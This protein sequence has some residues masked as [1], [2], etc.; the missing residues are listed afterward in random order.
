MQEL[1]FGKMKFKGVQ[2][3]IAKCQ[4][5]QSLKSSFPSQN[6]KLLFV[7]LQ[8]SINYFKGEHAKIQFCSK[9]EINYC[10]VYCEY[11]VKV[12]KI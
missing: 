8:C 9:F 11:K 1:K 7:V 3:S 12:I 4:I 10:C 6:N 5:H 2:V